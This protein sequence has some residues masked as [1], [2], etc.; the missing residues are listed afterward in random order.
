MV[1][2]PALV[3]A[4]CFLSMAVVLLVG[5]RLAHRL[6]TAEAEI[7]R[8]RRRTGERRLREDIALEPPAWVHP[9]RSNGHRVES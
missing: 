5:I 8:L 3:A 9:R 4:S 6:T 2:L 1:A 7:E